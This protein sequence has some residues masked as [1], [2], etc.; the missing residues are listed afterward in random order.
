A[1]ALAS[2]ARC[3]PIRQE[4][5][6]GSRTPRGGSSP[7]AY[8]R[9]ASH[10]A[11]VAAGPASPRASGWCRTRWSCATLALTLQAKRGSTISA[12]TMRRWLQEVGWVWKR[13][14]LVAKDDYPQR[15]TRLAHIRGVFEQLKFW[16]ALV[17]AD[18]M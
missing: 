8:Y 7:W 13:A 14:K 6:A 5:S 3:V 10:M 2:I 12:E 1:R 11:A 15:V 9:A 16:R 18:L 4:P 17:F